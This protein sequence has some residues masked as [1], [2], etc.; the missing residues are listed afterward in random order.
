MTIE[1]HWVSGSP[2]SWR[3]QLALEVKRLRY[4]SHLHQISTGELKTPAYL[5][6][7]PRG[8]VPTLVDDGYVLYESLAIL[9]YLDRKYPDPPLFGENAQ[10]TGLIWRCIAEYTA[11]ADAAVEAF[12]LPIYFG[13]AQQK[14]AQVRAAAAA[15]TFEL[16]AWNRQLASSA[17]FAGLRYSAADLVLFPAIKS[18]ERAAAKPAAKSLGIELLPI[19]AHWPHISAWVRRIEGLP[20]YERTYPPHWK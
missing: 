12:T 17:Y 18:I 6:L 14:A 4:V 13:E 1:L 20:G 5:A 15:L 2:Y 11:Y 7:N 19:A 9:T 16:D 8:L 10:A 3:V